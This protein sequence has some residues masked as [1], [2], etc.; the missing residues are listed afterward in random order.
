MV[1]GN[2]GAAMAA[3]P[4]GIVLAVGAGVFAVTGLAEAISGWTPRGIFR[5]RWWYLLIAVGGMFLG[6]G[7]KLAIGLADGTFPVR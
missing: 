6:W 2:L 3:Q 7:V 1:H 4:F 5:P